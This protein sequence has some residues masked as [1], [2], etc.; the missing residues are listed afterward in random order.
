V[1]PESVTDFWEQY[2][3]AGGAMAARPGACSVG[4]IG[5]SPTPWLLALGALAAASL[6]RARRKE[7]RS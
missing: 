6:G 2:E 1:T 4:A 5:S 3:R 7:P